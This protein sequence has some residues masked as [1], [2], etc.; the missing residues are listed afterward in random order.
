MLDLEGELDRLFHPISPQTFFA[1]T[2]ERKSLLIKVPPT[3][4]RARAVLANW[5]AVVAATQPGAG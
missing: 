3:S 1:R 5:K 2:W 4:S